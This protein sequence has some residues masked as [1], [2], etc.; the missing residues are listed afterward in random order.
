MHF[1]NDNHILTLPWPALSPDLNL[2]E[3]LWDEVGRRV[4]RR[5]NSL[6]SVDQLQGALRDE[7]NTIPQAFVMHLIGYMRRRCLAV[8]NARGGH[9]RY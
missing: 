1:L 4:R 2:I 9:A 5:V 8:L 7:W 6:E 3:H